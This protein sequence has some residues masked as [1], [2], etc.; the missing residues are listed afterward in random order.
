MAYVSSS[1]LSHYPQWDLEVLQ[2]CLEQWTMFR[3]TITILQHRDYAALLG[4][5][6]F[7][8]DYIRPKSRCAILCRPSSGHPEND[9]VL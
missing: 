5:S 2:E 1:F 6:V 4:G 9:V 7:F 3:C 8:E